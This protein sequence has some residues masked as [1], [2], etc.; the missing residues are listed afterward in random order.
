MVDFELA[1]SRWRA[2]EE[3]RANA[4]FSFDRAVRL[5]L[6]GRAGAPAASL[7]QDLAAQ[8]IAAAQ[9]RAEVYR[10][11]RRWRESVAVL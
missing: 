1:L 5:Y 2:A 10:A 8:A 6:L 11:L 3:A 9:A 7:A 4:Q